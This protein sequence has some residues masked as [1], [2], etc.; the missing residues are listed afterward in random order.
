MPSAQVLEQKKQIVIDM[1]EKLRNSQAGVFVS[2]C[3]L[4]VADDTELRKKM[5]EAGVD[6]F[7]VKNSM[8]SRASE[9][10]GLDEIKSVCEGTTAIALSGD[11][12]IA[13]A[14]ILNDFAESKDGFFEIKSG[15]MD[16]EVIPVEKVVA[17][18]KLPSREGLIAKMLGSLNAPITNLV[19]AIK[20]IHDKAEEGSEEQPA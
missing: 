9:A 5:R 1:V 19:Y 8:L 14:K 12:Y 11:D 4:T 2:Y 3:G 20:A 18:A 17:L 16:G 15:F 6:Y 7:V 13:A 10:A